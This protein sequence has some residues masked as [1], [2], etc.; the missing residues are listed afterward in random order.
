VQRCRYRSTL[1]AAVADALRNRARPDQACSVEEG[2][3]AGLMAT[4]DRFARATWRPEG[5]SRSAAARARA[6]VRVQ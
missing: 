4:H 6:S 3:P 5:S 2:G 1:E